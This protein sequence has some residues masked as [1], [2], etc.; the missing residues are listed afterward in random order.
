MFSN[1]FGI[2]DLRWLSPWLLAIGVG[3]AEPANPPFVLTS[4]LPVHSLTL[5][6]AG[7]RATV[8]NWLPPGVDPHDFQFSPR[9]LRK[10]ARA[11]LLVIGGLGLEGWKQE[12]LRDM[13][14][15]PRL[16]VIEAAGGLAEQSLIRDQG[17]NPHFWLDPILLMDAVNRVS[18]ALQNLDPPG[19]AE[20]ARNAAGYL[21]RLQSLHRDFEEGLRT[22]RGV[23]FITSHNAFPY[24]ARRYGLRLAGVVEQRAGEQP[25]AQRLADLTKLIRREGV[26]VLFTDSRPTQ[27]DRRL[28]SDL[29]LRLATLETLET[30]PLGLEAYETA[31]RRN[32][33][34]LQ[35]ALQQGKP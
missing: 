23:A 4:F 8:E 30:G 10:L 17:I 15:N 19:A 20:Y 7:S 28:A 26:K 6:V 1:A 24:L 12:D 2:S 3:A 14:G 16:T 18:T 21:E 25:G 34:A 5:A 32:L 13:S 22:S 35:A 33:A 29:Q 9:D 31:M 11:D 27:R